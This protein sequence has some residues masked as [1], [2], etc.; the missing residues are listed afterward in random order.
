MADYIQKAVK[1]GI[2]TQ[3]LGGDVWSGA[4]IPTAYKEGK[5][6]GTAMPDWWSSC[7]LKPGIPEM[8]GE[9]AVAPMPTWAGGGHK[10]TVWGG[11]GW[12]VSKGENQDIAWEFLK[13]MYMGEESQ[14]ERFEKINMFPVMFDAMKDP[15]VTGLAD[16]F[17]A[18]QKIGEIFADAGTDV[19]VWY[20]SPYRSD[21][22]TAAGNDLPGLFDGSM[23]PEAF[24]DDIIT[25]T[26]NAID[27]GS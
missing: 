11:T 27:F 2:F 25:Q 15:R 5:L 3:V 4:T 12:A 13:F 22:M 20:Q 24:V 6:A 26:Q 1:A 9:W 18:N 21:W 16:P 14:V 8:S 23:T 7:C 17:Y 19:P 10:T